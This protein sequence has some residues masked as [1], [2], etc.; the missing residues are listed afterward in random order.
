MHD[1]CYI[2][3]RKDNSPLLS[4][5]STSSILSLHPLDSGRVQDKGR[6]GLVVGVCNPSI[7]R[8]FAGMYDMLGDNGECV[9]IQWNGGERSEGEGRRMV[10]I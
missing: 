3:L 7:A 8:A 1:F 5:N 10:E 4:L 9:S 6:P 2:L